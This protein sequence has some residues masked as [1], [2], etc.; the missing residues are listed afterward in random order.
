[1]AAEKPNERV[2]FSE[3]KERSGRDHSHASADLGVMTKVIRKQ[4]GLGN[5]GFNTPAPFHWD[6]DRQ[7]AYY[8][9]DAEVAAAWKASAPL[10]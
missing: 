8:V 9:M 2:Y 6:S 1:M 10:P 5:V 3:V 7:Q 4:F